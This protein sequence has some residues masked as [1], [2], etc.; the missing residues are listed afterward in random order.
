MVE[1]R[2]YTKRQIKQD[3][4]SKAFASIPTWGRDILIYQIEARDLFLSSPEGMKIIMKKY[5]NNR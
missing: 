3:Y 5:H 1:R 4:Y 2:V